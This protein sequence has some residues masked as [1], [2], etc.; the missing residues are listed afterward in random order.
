MAVA[1]TGPLAWEPPYATGA[2]TRNERGRKRTH[3]F[4]TFSVETALRPAAGDTKAGI[5]IPVSWASCL[6]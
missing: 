6:L 5:K 3:L 2:K 4:I 1:P